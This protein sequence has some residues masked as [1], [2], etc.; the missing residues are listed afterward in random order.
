MPPAKTE[1]VAQ[2]DPSEQTP[3]ITETVMDEPVA[4]FKPAAPAKR[5][6]YAPVTKGQIYIQAG[7]FSSEEN[8]QKL[9]SQ[10]S[11]F[12]PVDVAKVEM[13]EKTWWRVR[14]GPFAQT[15]DASQALEKVHAANLPDA[16]IIHE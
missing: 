10:L 3:T 2:A 6:N 8:A 11:D 9:S 1:Q 15:E 13:P 14:L 7:S 5:T 12:G 16:R 4:P